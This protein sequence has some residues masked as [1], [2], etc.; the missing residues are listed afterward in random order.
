M[1]SR[2][3]RDAELPRIEGVGRRRK[4]EEMKKILITLF[5][6]FLSLLPVAAQSYDGAHLKLDTA[7]LDFGDVQRKGG[8][9][10]REVGFVN[11]GSSPLVILSV[12]TSCSCLKADYSRKPVV[13]GGRGVI[14]IVYEARKMEL[15]VFH[16]VMQV[17]S[18]SV[19]GVNLITVQGNSLDD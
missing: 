2:C 1:S 16:R 3:L 7:A 9:L 10:V 6:S 4:I 14:K 13:P 15:G 19:D 17:R 11:D 18:N 5:I 12:T 8:D